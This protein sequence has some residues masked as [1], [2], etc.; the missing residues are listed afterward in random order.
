MNKLIPP[1]AGFF[2]DT[3]YTNC[4]NGSHEGVIARYE[5]TFLKACSMYKIFICITVPA[6][7]KQYFVL[8]NHT[9][10]SSLIRVIR[11]NSCDPAFIIF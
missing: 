5:A 11:T 4:T 3:N 6:F 1:L 9:Y 7:R 2:L 8:R 10:C